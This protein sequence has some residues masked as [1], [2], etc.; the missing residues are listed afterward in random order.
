MTSP[1]I[2]RPT[3]QK[4]KAVLTLLDVATIVERI[5]GA[6]AHLEANDVLHRDVAARN[7][8]VGC[9]PTDVKL[10]DLGAARSVFR[11]ADKE[12][13]ATTDHKPARW[14]ALESLK[15]AKFTNKTDVWAF[16]VFC[17]EVSTLAKTPYGAMGV[18]DM[19]DSLVAGDRLPEA[20]FTPPG[21]YKQMLLCWSEEPKRRPRF[22]DLIHMLGAIRGALAVTDDG[23]ATLSYDNTVNLAEKPAVSESEPAHSYGG[24]AQTAAA[25]LEESPYSTCSP[26]SAEHSDYH[27]LL[28]PRIVQDSAETVSKGSPLAGLGGVPLVEL[29]VAAVAAKAHVTC[30]MGLEDEVALALQFAAMII[31]RGLAL[32]LNASQIA[33]IHLYTQESPLYG[34][35][36]GALGGY[37]RGGR[38]ALVHY[39]P[40]IKIALGALKLLPPVAI[41]VYR[42]VRD[43]P[44]RTLLQGQGVNGTLTWWTLTSTTSTPDVLRDPSFLGIGPQQGERVVFKM[45]VTTGVEIKQFSEF[46]SHVRLLE[47]QHLVCITKCAR[48]NTG[49]V[50]RLH[51]LKLRSLFLLTC[52]LPMT[53]SHAKVDDY[54][55]PFGV[56]EVQSED[57][58]MVLP[59][60]TFRIIAI[61]Y[62]ANGV[63]EVVL[64]EIAAAVP[65]ENAQT[66]DRL[67]EVGNV[68]DAA[69]SSHYISMQSSGAKPEV[70]LDGGGGGSKAASSH[71]ISSMQPIDPAASVLQHGGGEEAPFSHYNNTLQSIGTTAEVALVGGGGG[72]GEAA[73]SHYISSLQPINPAAP[74][75][76][77]GGVVNVPSSHYINLANA[78][79]RL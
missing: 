52:A 79:T 29:V 13:S 77:D 22:Q 46:G 55:T 36:N 21:L 15:A 26:L 34:G 64:E 72:G 69:T 16:A 62:Y 61:N 19:V 40:Y 37:G 57:E 65:I 60:T 30:R 56:E 75:L 51:L 45:H 67:P 39:L 25:S 47:T 3:L 1:P 49:R 66:D 7:V 74:A 58:V 76:Q 17:W 5:C 18:K 28:Y 10:A 48:G 54:L 33:S 8:L 24:G 27:K 6:L 43:V 53:S 35:M 38:A 41:T 50:L 78:K 32:G 70:A 20:P 12:Y 73:S 9:K 4:P 11:T 14:M 68:R 71:Y 2:R 23:K 59:G 44:L 42:A 63:I 31:E